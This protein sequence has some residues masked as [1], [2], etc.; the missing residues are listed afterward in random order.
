MLFKMTQLVFYATRPIFSLRHLGRSA[1]GTCKVFQFMHPSESLL[2]KKG[3]AWLIL[4]CK[5]FLVCP[6]EGGSH[7]TFSLATLAA[8]MIDDQQLHNNH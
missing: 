8:A 4:L 1:A 7:V 2:I 3:I 6:I 5:H